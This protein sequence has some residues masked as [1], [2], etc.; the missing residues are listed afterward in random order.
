MYPFAASAASALISAIWQGT[1][2]A[3]CVWLCLRLLPAV[4]AAVRSSIWL[5][6]FAIIFLLH[7]MP[8]F[9][10]GS[11]G[12]P[13]SV[14]TPHQI[15]AAPF[16]SLAV[17]G[18][19]LAA[20]TLRLVQ[21]VLGAWRLR[22]V[23][24]QA[25]PMPVQPS[26]AQAARGYTLCVSPDVDRPSVLGFWSPRILLPPG[27]MESLTQAELEQVLLHETE[28]LRRADDWTNLLQKLALI[29][30][31]L[32][33]V[34]FWVER[35][36]CLERELACDDRV[37]HETGARKAY[38]TCLTQLAEHSMLRRG[39]VLALG[40]WGKQSELATRVHRILRRPERTLSPAKTRFATA[41]L[42]AGVLAA[43]I[44]LARTP[45]L[46]SFVPA[47]ASV[48]AQTSNSIPA[49]APTSAPVLAQAR[50]TVQ[51]AAAK[52]PGSFH[53]VAPGASFVNT[54][55]ELGRSVQKP[56]QLTATHKRAAA[57][58]SRGIAGSGR[59]RQQQQPQDRPL[60][61]AT[62]AEHLQHL[63]LSAASY[64]PG[65][66]VPATYA[67]VQTPDGWIIFQL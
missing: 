20:S 41:A 67:A 22:M 54:S 62:R 2:L 61:T 26:I 1:L 53:P 21:F 4:S 19:S 15:H 56:V 31:P 28:H 60:F 42:M 25:V 64:V 10:S 38:A 40:A 35:Q 36:L 33:P 30:F 51:A 8:G 16:W 24:R 17:V 34:L 66:Y 11:H 45:R 48:L 23:N 47:G 7:F 29:L 13:G 6:T 32:N 58:T 55:L 65:A 27:L 44:T 37:L 50:A 14:A 63:Y 18:V 57:K 12:A 9:V 52:N 5:A 3:F 59:A 39:L 49:S 43:S 46:V